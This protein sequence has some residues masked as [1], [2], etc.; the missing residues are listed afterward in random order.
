MIV[1]YVRMSG[2]IRI[3]AGEGYI[4]GL[5]GGSV[6]VANPY[7]ILAQALAEQGISPCIK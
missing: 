4:Q 5:Y 1:Y 7:L 3:T 6:L 2:T